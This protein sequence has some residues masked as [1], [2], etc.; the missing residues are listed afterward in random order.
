[1]KSAHRGNRF[2][3][4]KELIGRFCPQL[5]ARSPEIYSNHLC[6]FLKPPVIAEFVALVLVRPLVDGQVMILR[7]RFL[8]TFFG[9][10]VLYCA[11]A[12]NPLHEAAVQN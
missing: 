3:F 11:I 8:L 9:F 1:M 2:F 4:K 12:C 5:V 10:G 7:Q 6:P